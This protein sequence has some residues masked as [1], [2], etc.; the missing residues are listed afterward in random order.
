MPETYEGDDGV[1]VP[2]GSGELFAG[3]GFVEF[4]P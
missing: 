2:D 1:T 4:L 3:A